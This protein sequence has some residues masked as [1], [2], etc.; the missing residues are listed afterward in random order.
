MLPA[1]S[2]LKPLATDLRQVFNAEIVSE[3]SVQM[4]P[5]PLVIKQGKYTLFVGCKIK[6]NVDTYTFLNAS[7]WTWIHAR[8]IVKRK[9][10]S[11]TKH[12]TVL[13]LPAAPVSYAATFAP[14]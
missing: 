2:V 4:E 10:N 5:G 13:G 8:R 6:L 3:L 12:P 7:L 14:S 1:F 11:V 9:G